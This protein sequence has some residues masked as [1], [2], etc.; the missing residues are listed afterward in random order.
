MPVKFRFEPA[1]FIAAKAAG[2]VQSP[3][4]QMFENGRR[5]RLIIV[6]CKDAQPHEANPH[7]VSACEKM[8]TGSGRP[9]QDLYVFTD[10]PVPVAIFSQALSSALLALILR[11]IGIADDLE[12]L[13]DHVL[14]GF[15]F[16]LGLKV[17][18]D[19]MA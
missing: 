1:L 14:T 13:P 12:E 9:T 11:Q 5:L 18:A 15:S 8:G 16:R 3:V 6:R 17:G 4:L 19:A 7:N 10:W 2:Y